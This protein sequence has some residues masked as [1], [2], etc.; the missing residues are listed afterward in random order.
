[1]LKRYRVRDYDFKLVV[2]LIAITLIGILAIGSANAEYQSKQIA[3]L[4]V[5]LF[6]MIV[7]S[8]FDYHTFYLIQLILRLIVLF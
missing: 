3:G 8:L 7:L 6:I 5:G 4:I 2:M 1:M